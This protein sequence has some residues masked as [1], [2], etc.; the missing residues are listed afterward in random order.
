M[1]EKNHLETIT[2]IIVAYY[3]D[4][5]NLFK[6]IHKIK[7]NSIKILIIDNTP[8]ISNSYLD[9]MFVNDEIFYIPLFKN[10]GIASAQNIGISYCID[11]IK[12]KF[13]LFLDQDSMVD[14]NFVNNIISEYKIAETTSLKISVLA[15]LLIEKNTDKYYRI[16]RLNRIENFIKTDKV[17]S[18]GSLI[19]L[20]TFKIVGLFNEDLYIDYVDSEW[21]WRA[22]KFN[23][24]CY[25][26]EKVKIL[27]SIG[28]SRFKFLGLT[29]IISDNK[30]YYFQYRN[31]IK[32]LR[33]S[34][35]PLSWKYKI[36]I[37]NIIFI[38]II[39]FYFK[40]YFEVY[41]FISLGI[42]DGFHSKKI[43]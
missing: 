26:S 29:F 3:P 30:R 33:V 12:S 22:S 17:S 25:I 14:Y 39:P 20:N 41:K 4:D 27:H 11:K 10:I 2:V 16:N 1:L 42:L 36:A 9:H 32:L 38:F 6:L 40:N 18:S 13:I 15:P 7:S 21:C 5:N 8:E 19:A 23:L 31:F 34:Y 35:V 28:I 43:I 37:K 24:S